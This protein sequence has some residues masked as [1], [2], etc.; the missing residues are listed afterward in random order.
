MKKSDAQSANHTF[1]SRGSYSPGGERSWSVW[2]VHAKMLVQICT[3]TSN[4]LVTARLLA[5]TPKSMESFPST[6]T[7]AILS[8]CCN[9]WHIYP[10]RDRY[11]GESR[12]RVVW[13]W[14]LASARM[15]L[16]SDCRRWYIPRMTWLGRALR[17]GTMG[18]LWQTEIQ[19]WEPQS[20]QR[21][22]SLT[23]LG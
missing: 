14:Q 1:F 3:S 17:S 20:H 12:G 18:G 21:S 5:P 7:C 15:A 2:E 4:C 13:Y 11:D 19:R 8:R 9:S 22:L 10:E 23:P 6:R 16:M